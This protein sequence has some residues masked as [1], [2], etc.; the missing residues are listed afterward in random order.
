MPRRFTPTP[1]SLALLAALAPL[2]EAVKAA[3]SSITL[4]PVVITGDRKSVV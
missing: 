3:D 1:L 2:S 4:N